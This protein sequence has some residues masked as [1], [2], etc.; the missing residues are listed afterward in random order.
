[1]HCQSPV[2]LSTDTFIL[3]LLIV[4]VPSLSPLTLL[5]FFLAPS[6][7]PLSQR[8]SPWTF[9]GFREVRTFNSGGDT[10]HHPGETTI[11]VLVFIVCLI[12]IRLFR[13]PESLFVINAIGNQRFVSIKTSVAIAA[14]L[15]EEREAAFKTVG[16]KIAKMRADLTKVFEDATEANAAEKR[17]KRLKALKLGF[18]R[19]AGSRAASPSLA[20]L[21]GKSSLDSLRDERK[22]EV[23]EKAAKKVTVQALAGV[24]LA[25]KF[26]G[27]LLSK[28]TSSSG[29]LALKDTAAAATAAIEKEEGES[30]EVVSAESDE[31]DSTRKKEAN[32]SGDMSKSGDQKHDANVEVAPIV[33]EGHFDVDALSAVLHV[34]YL[35]VLET[36]MHYCVRGISWVC[37][38]LFLFLE[39]TVVEVFTNS[40]TYVVFLA[41]VIYHL[42]KPTVLSAIIPATTFGFALL[43]NPMALPVPTSKHRVSLIYDHKRGR[44]LSRQARAMNKAWK[45]KQSAILGNDDEG[46]NET[47]DAFLGK[48]KIRS[49]DNLK[50]KAKDKTMGEEDAAEGKRRTLRA[51][52]SA[53]DAHV[54][55]LKLDKINE[56]F[57]VN[58]N[59][60]F[61][62]H[63]MVQNPPGWYWTFLTLYINFTIA[64]KFLFQFPIVCICDG[65]TSYISVYP[66][67][68]YSH[69]LSIRNN[70]TLPLTAGQGNFMPY[71]GWVGLRKVTLDSDTWLQETYAERNFSTVRREVIEDGSGLHFLWEV[72]PEIILMSI[73]LLHNSVLKV[74]GVWYTR[75]D[76]RDVRKKR[77]S[78]NASEEGAVASDTASAVTNADNA[79]DNGGGKEIEEEDKVVRQLIEAETDE[80]QMCCGCCEQPSCMNDCTMANLQHL[81][82]AGIYFVRSSGFMKE[83]WLIC[84]AEVKDKERDHS[85]SYRPVPKPGYDFYVNIFASQMVSF[86]FLF[87]F[88]QSYEDLSS[89]LQGS[90]ALSW[91]YV[92]VIIGQFTFIV[93]DR[94][95]YLYRSIALKLIL[96]WVWICIVYGVLHG[97]I[98]RGVGGMY[99]GNENST[100][101]LFFYIIQIPYLFFSALQICYGYP[102][103]LYDQY[104]MRSV[105]WL[106]GYI[107][108]GYQS[109]PFL[110]EMRTLLD[111]TCT[112]TTLYLFEWLKL[113]SIRTS[114][115]LVQC[116][117]EYYREEARVKGSKQPLMRKISVGWLLFVALF[118]VLFMPLLLFSNLVRESIRV[119]LC[120]AVQSYRQ[121][122][123]PL[124]HSL[125]RALPTTIPWSRSILPLGC[126]VS[127]IFMV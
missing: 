126:L 86:L 77:I 18:N 123:H 102:T 87:L 91:Q 57:S 25:A 88:F 104:L 44:D 109:L 72:M 106:S 48:E 54:D 99:S 95:A 33:T 120:S 78:S 107:F 82:E 6:H 8:D 11:D 52:K 105:D 22:E 69:D 125:R 15:N 55:D 118:A 62:L 111:W 61:F 101:L 58:D 12:Q 34:D 117:L 37:Q 28:R 124:S 20:S 47:V 94:I 98:G 79:T 4:F 89:G 64:F 63:P 65:T 71:T 97:I 39:V 9:F 5:A 56:Q 122:I 32:N 21:F 74:R 41:M 31:S 51:T 42:W 113:E 84:G 92:M 46:E 16:N 1:M 76:V 70:C 80:T 90:T 67:C 43:Q 19:S 59:G 114:L 127:L 75:T 23:V 7:L 60:Q 83:M 81:Y 110:Y 45:S 36:A 24:S 26:A 2:H 40:S 30:L 38:Q 119:L 13:A 93:L 68:N 116:N 50:D 112:N 27:R 53:A 73:I 66:W 103:F 14:R 49:Y 29:P 10:D 3:L 108:I 115:Y 121:L 35:T 85:V 100:K 96:H 17:T